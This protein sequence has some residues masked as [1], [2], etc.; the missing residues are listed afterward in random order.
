M[1]GDRWLRILKPLQ[2]LMY[3]I[4]EIMKTDEEDREEISRTHS[5]WAGA[6]SSNGCYEAFS[7]IRKIALIP[8]NI[9]KCLT[10]QQFNGQRAHYVS[11][12]WCVCCMWLITHRQLIFLFLSMFTNHMLKICL[13]S[14][15][16]LCVCPSISLHIRTW[17]LLNGF[18]LNMMLRNFTKIWSATQFWLR[19]DNNT[20]FITWRK[21]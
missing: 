19:L 8:L 1:G 4:V 6:I 10:D 5:A 21:Y 14:L 17:E 18:S 2:S 15:P 12:G 20:G 11:S 13:L 7:V 9:L 16:F 3:V